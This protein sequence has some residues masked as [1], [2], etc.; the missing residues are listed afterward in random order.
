MISEK[1]YIEYR[2]KEIYLLDALKEICDKHGLVFWIDFGTLLGAVRQKGFIPWDDD[3]DVSMPV[4]DY[5]KFLKI[6]EKELPQDIFLQ[7]AKTDKAYKQHFAKLC[8]CYSTF[9]HENETG[10]ESY[11]QGIYIDIF[12][13]VIYPKMPD[14]LRKGLLYFTGRSRAKAVISRENVFF[15]YSIY[16]LCKFIWL[17]LSPFKS[18]KVAQT[19]EDNWYYYAI[20][21]SYIY[22]LNYI[23]FESK[24]Y[25]AP[26]KVHEYLSLMYGKDYITPPPP[27]K[28]ITRAKSILISTPG[29]HPRALQKHG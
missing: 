25:P 22:P 3:I 7:T 18:D 24:L 2:K 10:E 16:L 6:A 1:D 13:S 27:E 29:N 17:L 26:K 9:L 5:K 28:R 14:F 23:E 21:K 8:D 20:P 4:E 11:H 15:N 12:P 19:V